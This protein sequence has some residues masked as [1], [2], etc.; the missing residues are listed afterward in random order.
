MP[1]P[2]GSGIFVC[3]SGARGRREDF[4]AG[5]LARRVFRNTAS[6]QGIE[7]KLKQM[8]EAESGTLWPTFVLGAREPLITDRSADQ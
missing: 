8:N 3:R 4:R 6:G 2:Q 1:E 7:Q 5:T